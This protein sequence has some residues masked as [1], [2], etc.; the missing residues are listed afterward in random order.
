MAMWQHTCGV[1]VWR[2]VGRCK[3]DWVQKLY[4]VQ[5][6]SPHRTP[7]IHTTRMLPHCHNGPLIFLV[8]LN[9]VTLTRKLRAA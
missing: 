6:A 4:A 1:Y 5:L 8:I 7:Y 3:L 9:S 2:S